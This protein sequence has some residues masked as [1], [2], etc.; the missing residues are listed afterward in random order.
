MQKTIFT[1][2]KC[3]AQFAKWTGRCLQCGNWGTIKETAAPLKSKGAPCLQGAPLQVIPFEQINTAAVSRLPTG[4]NEV[5]RVL[6]GGFV[7]GS[8]ILLG[9][10]PG[11]GKSSLVLQLAGA[12]G[13]RLG[14]ILYVSGEESGEQIKMRWERLKT[15]QS[16]HLEQNERPIA[17]SEY[18]LLNFLGETNA[19]VIIAALEKNR[20]ALAIIDSI[21]TVFSAEVEGEAGNINQIK[22][23]TAK[24]LEVAKKNKTIIILVG[25]VTKDGALAGPRAMEHLVDAVL[26][27]EGDRHHH[28]R[29]LRPVKNRFGST[30]EVGVFEMTA[31]GLKEVANP[32][33]AFLEEREEKI[34]GS[35]VT[36]LMEGQRPLLVEIQALVSKT[37]FG[38]PQR[39]S[40]GFDITRLQVLLAVL[41]RR[42]KLPLDSYDVH[43]NV[44]GG[45]EANEPA[46]DLAVALAVA[47]AFKD[48]V[49]PAGLVAFGE[50]GLGGEVRS[51][52]QLEKRLQEV[53]NLGFHYAVMPKIKQMPVISGLKLAPI[54]NLS[55]VI[56]LVL[57]T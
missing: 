55:E 53:K 44:V 18:G 41:N 33:A 49:L 47:S 3:G 7:P 21:Q 24:L 56:E 25:Q 28:F 2:A 14:G 39:R 16:G 32:S 54:K 1:C 34:P 31:Q 17:E 23:C 26:Y 27:L 8:L 48:K 30:A 5:D 15:T 6:G 43:L 35:I 29:L 40:S 22:A 38:Y 50:V 4:I 20:P 13:S 45:L 19:E 52:T 9:G 10:E 46:C 11:I 37:S 57:K 42:A 36:C 12:L 51:V